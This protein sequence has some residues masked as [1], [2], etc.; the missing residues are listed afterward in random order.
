MSKAYLVAPDGSL[1]ALQ[2]SMYEQTRAANRL[3]SVEDLADA[4]LLLVSEKSRWITAQFI[5]VNGGI[6]GTT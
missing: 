4:T 3:G 6:T 5:S 1:T 2:L